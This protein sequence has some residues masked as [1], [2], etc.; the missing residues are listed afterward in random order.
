[1]S[2]RVA[3]AAGRGAPRVTSTKSYLS[4]YTFDVTITQLT[5]TL[6]EERKRQGI[7]KAQLALRSQMQSS[8]VRKILGARS[9]DVKVSTLSKIAA[10][11]G[12]AITIEMVDQG[13]DDRQSA[14]LMTRIKRRLAAEKIARRKSLDPGDVEHA[15]RCLDLTPTQRLERSF[16]RAR[17]RSK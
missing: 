1:L 14:D 7:S 6:D 16:R 17:S 12:A 3:R 5:K 10:A 9:E 4:R 15:L 13:L 11:L 8:A 2:T